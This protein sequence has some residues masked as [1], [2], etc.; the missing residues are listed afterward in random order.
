V[1]HPGAHDPLGEHDNPAA[2]ARNGIVS[3]DG[4]HF[5]ARFASDAEK[6]GEEAARLLHRKLPGLRFRS[7]LNGEVRDDVRVNVSTE[8]PVWLLVNGPDATKQQSDR[9]RMNLVKTPA[10]LRA[11]P[12]TQPLA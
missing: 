12:E 6:F 11:A 2:D 1:R 8:P 9:R 5:E 3:R 10:F 4:G 7:S